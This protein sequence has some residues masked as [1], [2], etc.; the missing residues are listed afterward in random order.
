MQN[1]VVHAGG[2]EGFLQLAEFARVVMVVVPHWRAVNVYVYCVVQLNVLVVG[3]GTL[4]GLVFHGN[5]RQIILNVVLELLMLG[6]VQHPVAI[7]AV[8]ALGKLLQLLQSQLDLHWVVAL[9]LLLEEE[10]HRLH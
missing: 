6:E 8:V 10:V 1:L 2:S 3:N 4:E 5:L 9:V 7:F